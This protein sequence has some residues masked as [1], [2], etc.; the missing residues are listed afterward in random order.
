[1]EPRINPIQ[2]KKEEVLPR[3]S[4]SYCKFTANLQGYVDREALEVLAK[5]GMQ[6]DSTIMKQNSQSGGHAL[7]RFVND[8]IQANSFN[9]ILRET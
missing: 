3:F 9:R 4:I 8:S 5:Y 2:Q 7:L 6:L 1:M